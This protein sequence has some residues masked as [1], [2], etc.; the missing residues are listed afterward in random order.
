MVLA[1]WAALLYVRGPSCTQQNGQL[2]V[3]T[4][5]N[6]QQQDTAKDGP[7]K[8][9]PEVGKSSYDQIAPVLIGKETFAEMKPKISDK[10]DT[11]IGRQQSLLKE[12]YILKKKVDD[13]VTMFRG[14]PIPVGLHGQAAQRYDVGTT[15]RH[16]RPSR[17]AIREPSPK[18]ICRLP[19]P[20]HQ[21][22]AWSSR[23]IKSRKLNAWECID[24]DFDLPNISCPNFPQPCS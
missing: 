8:T 6:D 4:T 16:G 2:D 18:D 19:H 22:G 11:V 12:R 23:S 7:G 14:K 3:G 9:Q 5:S 21:V 24:L 10:K 1:A 20:H 15:R 13:K 17:F